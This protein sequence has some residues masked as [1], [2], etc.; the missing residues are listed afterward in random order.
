MARSAALSGLAR[1]VVPTAMVAG[2]EPCTR[3]AC[4]PRF[5]NLSSLPTMPKLMWS[6]S[7]VGSVGNRSSGLFLEERGDKFL[8]LCPRPPSC[9]RVALHASA[10]GDVVKEDAVKLTGQLA[11]E[12]A[13][14][15]FFIVRE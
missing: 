9:P 13:D 11:I 1:G 12:K 10:R 15:A 14:V 6:S 7:A 2:I 4:R 3:A 5:H 8:R